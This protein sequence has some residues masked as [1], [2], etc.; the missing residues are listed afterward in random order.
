M[1]NNIFKKASGFILAAVMLLLMACT[2]PVRVCAEE[3]VEEISGT[4]GSITWR[5]GY[6]TLYNSMSLIISGEGD[7][8]TLDE[9]G[10]EAYPWAELNFKLITI[11]E[12]I[13]SIPSGFC[14]SYSLSMTLPE[15][16]ECIYSGAFGGEIDVLYVTIKSFDCIFEE[17]A[18]NTENV[19]SSYI[20]A[21]NSSTAMEFANDNGLGFYSLGD[22]NFGT[23]NDGVFEYDLYNDFAA[24]SAYLGEESEITIPSE[25]EGLPVRKIG[26]GVFSD[27]KFLTSVIIPDS[28]ESIGQKAFS[29]C[30]SLKEVIIPDS[31]YGMGDGVFSGCTSLEVIDLPDSITFVTNSAFEDCTSLSEVIIP[32]SAT[33]I[34]PYAFKGCTALTQIELPDSITSIGDYAFYGLDLTSIKLPMN[35]N[36][37][38]ELA[39]GECKNLT[40]IELPE[41]IDRIHYNSFYNTPA[42]EVMDFPDDIDIILDSN[43]FS[44]SQ[45]GETNGYVPECI[46]KMYSDSYKNYENLYIGAKLEF[47][48]I[49]NNTE[50]YYCDRELKNIYIDEANPYFCAE[51]GV[52][53]NKDRTEIIYIAKS[54]GFEN[55]TMTIPATVKKISC[56]ISECSISFLVV[57]E[58]NNYF[59]SQDGILYN[60]DKTEIVCIPKNC[61]FENGVLNISAALKIIPSNIYD[62]N[63]SSICVEEG[64]NYFSSQDG[65][66]FDAEKKTLIAYPAK[67]TDS[68]YIVPYGTETISKQSFYESQVKLIEI[69]DSV[70]EIEQGAFWGTFLEAIVFEH[71][72]TSALSIPI[73]FEGHNDISDNNYYPDTL[74]YSYK[75]SV[76]ET[77]FPDNFV[78]M[79]RETS[80]SCGNDLTWKYSDFNLIIKGS[81][82][83]TT[84]SQGEY[85]WSGFPCVDVKFEGSDITISDY[86][87]AQ[88]ELLCTLDLTGVTTIGN[89]AFFF[90][91]NLSEI[92]GGDGVR[93]IKPY[94][95]FNTEWSDSVHDE[96]GMNIL[97]SV[98]VKYAGTS[99]TAEIPDN[100]T[101]VA[102][103][104]FSG[105][106]CDTLYVP[107]KGVTYSGGAFGNNTSIKHVRFKDTETDVTYDDFKKAAKLCTEKVF[108]DSSGN[109]I[110]GMTFTSDNSIMSLANAIENTPYMEN[111]YDEYCKNIISLCSDNMT[112]QQIIDIIYNYTNQNID[113]G[114][115][116]IES[117]YGTYKADDT[118]YELCG[119]L[120]HNPA[121]IVFL[122]RGVCSAFAELVNIYATLVNETGISDTLY[123]ESVTGL[124]HEWNA[125]GLDAGTENEK[126]Y[127]MDLSNR[128]YL[129]GYENDILSLNPEMFAYDSELTENDDGTYTVTLTSGKVINI[130][131]A[132]AELVTVKGDVNGDGRVMID[133][134]TA[135]LAIYAETAAGMETSGNTAAADIDG[136][137]SID[138]TDA[139]AILTY[140]AQYSAGMDP[141]WN[142]LL[143]AG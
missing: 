57:E 49:L 33:V 68:H 53:Y 127:Y 83:M 134:A 16:L 124:N 48:I 44:S 9:L 65:V 13:T 34:Y 113:Y 84:C 109:E 20:M 94:G 31:V 97:G 87:F 73:D 69:P 118:Y 35:L 86:A 107:E 91:K 88:N 104:A 7:I 12:G 125:I 15:S 119:G 115:T 121:G 138:I 22:K 38:G 36:S 26:K 139:T 95:I 6:D 41:G 43:S 117:P 132:D 47:F 105:N 120:A 110:T 136:N 76:I 30:T 131:S 74:Y 102:S 103:G 128:T 10:L 129:I 45:T 85:P 81:G 96:T 25:A 77:M 79:G 64:N 98:L 18:F 126:W 90:C 72:S 108:I 42:M 27:C 67:K 114:F 106:I 99:S 142:V 133:D 40:Y 80:G 55:G 2:M 122:N 101:Y 5:Y 63:I 21:Y 23:Y 58:G 116:Y 14:N 56:D 75:G 112:D 70:N 50:S 1:K 92:T 78:E 46:T 82:E 60:K 59:S 17:N 89:S 11:E 24:V 37:I 52:L 123:S 100:V 8:P 28:V 29:G 51:D 62:Y 71:D 111:I 141:D 3:T 19:T 54:H 32:E 93:M 66:L 137:G 39:F 61:E 140:Y 135:V 130:Q 4:L 143:G